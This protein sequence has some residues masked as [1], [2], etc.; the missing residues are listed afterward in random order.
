M[1]RYEDCNENLVQVFLSIV[2]ER[3]PSFQNLKFKLIFDTKRRIKGGK[4]TLASIEVASDKIKFFSKD[5]IALDGYDYVII[6]DK[7]AWELASATDKKR[8]MSHEMRHVFV[9]EEKEACKVIGHEIEDF[10]AE[11]KLNQDDPEWAL[12]LVTLVSD[13]YEQEKELAREAK[14]A[15]QAKKREV[16]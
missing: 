7:K 15:K 14:Q 13:V 12:K 8:I 2:E 5:K 4:T 6:V 16:L 3:F 9:D 1:N 10:Y 11:I